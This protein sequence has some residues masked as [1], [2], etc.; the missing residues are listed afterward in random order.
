M[1]KKIFPFLN[2]SFTNWSENI[3]NK[4]EI[5]FPTHDKEIIELIHKAKE[6]QQHIRVV[7]S[8]HS[9]SPVICYSHEQNLMLISLRDYKLHPQDIIIDHKNKLVQVNAGWTLAQLYQ[10]L[11]EYNYFLETQPTNYSLTISGITCMPVCG[12]HLSSSF[13]ADSLISMT[14]IDMHGNNVIKHNTE[15]DF[16]LY[17]V[18]LGLFG[19]VTSL[20]FRLREMNTLLPQLTTHYNIF[21]EDVSKIKKNI[22]DN[23]FK[24]KIYKCFYPDRSTSEYMNCFI[25]FHNNILVCLDWKNEPRRISP[26][27][28]YPDTGYIYKLEALDFFFKN[29]DKDFRQNEMILNMLGKG[30]RFDLM[31]N[32]EQNAQNQADMLLPTLDLR[33]YSMS[34]FIPLCMEGEDLNLDKLYEPIEFVMETIRKFKKQNSTY[35]LDFL[36]DFSFVVSTNKSIISPIYHKHKKIVYISLQ[37]TTLADNL[38]LITNNVSSSK[39]IK[40]LNKDFRKFFHTIEQK[41]ISLDGVPHWAK[42]FGFDAQHKDP[43]SKKIIS[44]LLNPE[45]KKQLKAK[46]QSLFMNDF[47]KV[48]L[49]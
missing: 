32:I 24:D 5:K 2:K 20:T 44:E 19:I 29:I 47:M 7:G 45:L 21:Y 23:Y 3:H 26:K 1:L 34:Y 11:N 35:A 41:W 46:A 6:K 17:R 13:I 33:T 42:M 48:L 38:E 4:I 30:L 16:D 28:H 36:A 39:L 25:D 9:I 27:G 15:D 10:S 43:F 49:K 37:I 18:N 14:L 22:L 40:Q 31:F 8:G 12:S